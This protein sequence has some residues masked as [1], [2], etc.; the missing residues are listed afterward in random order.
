M[1]F[2]QTLFEIVLKSFI[3]FQFNF[4]TLNQNIMVIAKMPSLKDGSILFCDLLPV[5]FETRF[6]I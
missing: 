3:N 1:T 2:V 4:R 6:Q 5:F